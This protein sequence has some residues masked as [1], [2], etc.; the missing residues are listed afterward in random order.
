M[1]FKLKAKLQ[2]QKKTD[3][4]KPPTLKVN[5]CFFKKTQEGD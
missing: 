1:S 4:E 2:Q 3:K 5:L